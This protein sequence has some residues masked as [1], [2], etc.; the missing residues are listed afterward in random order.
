[1]S[2]WHVFSSKLIFNEVPIRE[3]G[4]DHILA[5]KMWSKVKNSCLW[6]INVN[7]HSSHGFRKNKAPDRL[8]GA[9]RPCLALGWPCNS[10]VWTWRRQPMAEL[11][12]AGL[13][14]AVRGGG[15][16]AGQGVWQL[17]QDGFPTLSHSL[18]LN[19][20]LIFSLRR[21]NVYLLPLFIHPFTKH[22]ISESSWVR[23]TTHKFCGT[24]KL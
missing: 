3:H 21:I 11:A 2:V 24:S 15:R 1:M 4:L 10:T 9:Q 22:S 18:F 14:H 17:S 13:F 7:L 12:E 16:G 8:H 19:W 6:E 23:K 5:T 20:T